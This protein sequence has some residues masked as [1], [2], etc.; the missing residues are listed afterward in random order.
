MINLKML[1][2]DMNYFYFSLSHYNVM[3]PWFG[4]KAILKMNQGWSNAG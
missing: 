2:F 1:P 3:H 4:G